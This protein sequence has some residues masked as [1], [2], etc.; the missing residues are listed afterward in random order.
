M[1]FQAKG[2]QAWLIQRISALYISIYLCYVSVVLISTESMSYQQWSSWLSQPLMA[3]F[4]AV[5]FLLLIMHVWVG[6]RD[7]T[8]DY[9]NNESTRLFLLSFLLI[10]LSA[11]YLF[12]IRVL[13]T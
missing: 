3:T 5:F 12:F 2:L 9:V 1:S 10:F 13:F 7:I 6:V 4:T 11:C 8:I